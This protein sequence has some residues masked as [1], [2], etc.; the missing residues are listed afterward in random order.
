MRNEYHIYPVDLKDLNRQKFMPH[1][2]TFNRNT[3][4]EDGQS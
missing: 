2:F 4:N 1:S 3:Y